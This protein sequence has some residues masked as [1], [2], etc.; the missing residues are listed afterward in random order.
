MP[1]IAPR[2][3]TKL[4]GPDIGVEVWYGFIVVYGGTILVLWSTYS[5]AILGLGPMLMTVRLPRCLFQ[6]LKSGFLLKFTSVLQQDSNMLK[7]R[8]QDR[9]RPTSLIVFSRLS[10]DSYLAGLLYKWFWSSPTPQHPNWWKGSKLWSLLSQ[11]TLYRY[12]WWSTHDFWSFPFQQYIMK[13]YEEAMKR[14]NTR[15][16]K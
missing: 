2:E 10:L 3:S 6:L 4:L 13:R 8:I 5:Q 15:G 12:S 11:L 1:N 9:G 16:F 7:G 14:R